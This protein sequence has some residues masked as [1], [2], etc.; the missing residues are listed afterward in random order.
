MK[1]AEEREKREDGGDTSRVRGGQGGE[2]NGKRGKDRR[3]RA[4]GRWRRVRGGKGPLGAGSGN[5]GDTTELTETIAERVKESTTLSRRAAF[6]ASPRLIP[7]P[8]AAAAAA[9][10]SSTLSLRCTR[11]P[12]PRLNPRRMVVEP[13]LHATHGSPFIR[14]LFANQF[15]VQR[16]V[17]LRKLRRRYA[18]RHDSCHRQPSGRSDIFSCELRAYGNIWRECARCELIETFADQMFGECN[19]SSPY[20]YVIP[21]G[22]RERD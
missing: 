14:A 20:A 4:S 10:L 9:Y 5:L 22:G 18:S 16:R 1:S 21:Y 6:L 19:M 3:Q 8:A 15:H 17:A 11:A 7:P 13:L 2:K 12:T